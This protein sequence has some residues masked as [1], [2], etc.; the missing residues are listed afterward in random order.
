VSPFEYGDYQTPMHLATRVVQLIHTLQNKPNS[1]LE[2]TC[3]LG[4]LLAAALEI[5]SFEVVQG[6]ELNPDYARSAAERLPNAKIEQGNFFAQNLNQLFLS[7]PE[8]RLILGNPPW[9]TNASMGVVG[10]T[11]LPDKQN[12]ENLNGMAARTGKSNFDISESM[13]LR[14]LEKIQG[15]NDALIVIVKTS[16]AR[17]ILKFAAQHS[18]RVQGM[19][20]YQINAKQDFKAAVDASVFIC[21]GS[22]KT[23][24]YDCPIF[25][26]LEHSKP[27]RIL[28]FKDNTLVANADAYALGQ[29]FLG[30]SHLEWRSGIKHDCSSIM[31]LWIKDTH[32]ENGLGELVDLETTYLYPMLKSSDLG[33]ARTTPRALML[34]PQ[35]FIGEPT[36]LLELTAPKTWAYLNLHRKKLATRGSSIYKNQPEFAIFG[37][38]TYSF[39]PWKVAISGMYKRLEFSLLAP[40]Q[41]TPI[42]F[43][44]TCYFLPCRNEAEARVL[45]A[46]VTTPEAH[47]AL[48]ALVFW[49]EK[50]PITK[51][52]LDRLE[53]PKV[54]VA[55]RSRILPILQKTSPDLAIAI[56]KYWFSL[57]QQA[58]ADVP[59]F[60]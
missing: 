45:H 18:W 17:K 49:D 53:L 37:I 33:N 39:A 31:E 55:T 22:T 56:H 36:G 30:K 10:G 15:T 3:G 16:V 44:D 51:E 2:P 47:S 27:E 28:T 7:L 41:E 29:Q 20:M 50:R 60:A 5:Q 57:E 59:L 32:L 19:S 4:N 48:N 11:N 43:D 8:P 52:R 38:G 42:V 1:I 40:I 12:L 34:V 25:E 23:I 14:L 54:A 26:S 46:L 13:L 9:V 21:Q 24:S 58:F 35:T 6:L